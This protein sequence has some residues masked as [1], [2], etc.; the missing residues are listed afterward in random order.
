M[1]DHKPTH[2]ERAAMARLQRTQNCEEKRADY[3]RARGWTCTPPKRP[4]RSR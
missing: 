2:A 3:L 4:E 1:T